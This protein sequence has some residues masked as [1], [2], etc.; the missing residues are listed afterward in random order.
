MK[1]QL[2]MGF[3]REPDGIDFIIAPATYT[4]ADRAEVSAFFLKYKASKTKKGI[5]E[6]PRMKKRYKVFA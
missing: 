2:D 3:I 5:E 6:F 4:D 1:Y